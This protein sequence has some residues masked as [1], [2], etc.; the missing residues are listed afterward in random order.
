MDMVDKKA[1]R[2]YL[3]NAATT[4][5][6]SEV[7]EAMKPFMIEKY[8]NPSSIHWFGRETRTAVDKAREK[9]AMLIGAKEQEIVF[10]SGGSESDNL[11]LFGVAF[12]LKDKGRHIIT[13]SVEHH[14]VY[15]TCKFLEGF[16]FEVTY[17]PVDAD[18]CVHV[19]ELEHALRDD[20]ILVSVMHANNEVG[21]IQPIRE[22]GEITRK[23]GILL[24][25]D[26]V[27]TVGNIPVDVNE[28]NVDLLS[29]SAHKFHGPKGIGALYVRRGI[30]LIPHIHGGAQERNRRA[31]T[32][33]IAG[34]V[35]LAKALELATADLDKEVLR[36]SA[37]RDR[38][39]MGIEDKIDRVRLN[40]HRTRRLP[41]NVN[42]SFQYI[43]GESILLNLDLNGIAASSGSACTSG[44]LEPSHVLTSMGL[45]HETAHG[46]VRFTLGHFNTDEDVERV[47]EVLPGIIQ[48]LRE[49][50]PLWERR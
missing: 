5:M 34:I 44:S 24:H 20:T 33:N 50:S 48:R 40:G 27:Q 26:A 45:S 22:I 30:K 15:D 7:L 31:G 41:G 19:D 17:L 35:G 21:V 32:E 14:A 28:L 3:D 47:L 29:M 10:T 37:L 42:F 8:G 4:Q 46:S 25:A 38:L 18:G 39:I 2:V 43:E 11:A 1:R 9:V 13:S 36:I 16:G 23:K 6:R 49:M 12:A